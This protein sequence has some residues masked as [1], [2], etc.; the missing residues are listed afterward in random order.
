MPQ[1][2]IRKVDSFRDALTRQ[3]SESVR[4]D[5]RGENVLNS[6]TEYSRCCLPRLTIDK[7][8][9]TTA[10]KKQEE[11]V[12][13]AAGAEEHDLQKDQDAVAAGQL[14]TVRE[15][16]KRKSGAGGRKSKKRKLDPLQDWGVG[17]FADGGDGEYGE[18]MEESNDIQ[19]WL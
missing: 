14:D 13:V 6:K 8:A 11:M 3:I 2:R 19:C 15:A 1:F 5:L 4:I 9:W 17:E 18:V 12:D 7:E 16:R 10:R